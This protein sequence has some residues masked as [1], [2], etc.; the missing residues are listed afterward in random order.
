MELHIEPAYGGSYGNYTQTQVTITA[1]TPNNTSIPKRKTLVI[2][3]YNT[4]GEAVK[5]IRRVV[6]QEAFD[7]TYLKITSD[8]PI[9]VPSEG[10]PN[11]NIAIFGI[12]NLPYLEIVQEDITEVSILPEEPFFLCSKTNYGENLSAWYEAWDLSGNLSEE[13][14]VYM[15][16]SGEELP[17]EFITESTY[18]FCIPLGNIPS[19]NTGDIRSFHIRLLHNQLEEDIIDS[20][21]TWCEIQQFTN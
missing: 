12:S 3:G 10:L 11:A 13:E 4:K 14:N 7:A 1:L 17:E 8:I 5:E 9:Y 6:V 15:Y 21:E 18:Y 19:N 2:R 16:M 20:T